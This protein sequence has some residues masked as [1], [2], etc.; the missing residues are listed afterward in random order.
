MV[1]GKLETKLLETSALFELTNQYGET[2]SE[3]STQTRRSYVGVWVGG[4][5]WEAEWGG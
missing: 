5:T 3:Q 2:D 4:D 1:S